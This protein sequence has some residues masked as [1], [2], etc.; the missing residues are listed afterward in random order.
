MAATQSEKA[1]D[2][3]GDDV[4]GKPI[5][6]EAINVVS[7]E[8][9][10]GQRS[11]SNHLNQS[12]DTIMKSSM[13]FSMGKEG[14]HMDALISPL[15][16]KNKR[17][18]VEQCTAVDV[19]QNNNEPV[20]QIRT[21][22]QTKPVQ[23]FPEVVTKKSQTLPTREETMSLGENDLKPKR[24]WKRKQTPKANS[25][26]GLIREDLVLCGKKH[27][28]SWKI[29]QLAKECVWYHRIN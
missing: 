11:D 26:N 22:T 13:N 3:S 28:L 15:L 25:Q 5:I 7:K 21:L 9:K 1:V 4:Q 29:R 17:G 23:I 14:T 18:H 20:Y 27:D 6:E 10:E 24:T 12:L 16:A 8:N 2:V 19:D